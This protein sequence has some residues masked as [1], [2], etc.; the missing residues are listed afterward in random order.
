M[1]WMVPEM[2][3]ERPFRA[4]GDGSEGESIMAGEEI[5]LAPT[6]DWSTS[7]STPARGRGEVLSCLAAAVEE[8]SGGRSTGQRCTLRRKP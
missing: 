1:G 8:G 5:Q 7:S 2:E 3:E 6:R 4:A